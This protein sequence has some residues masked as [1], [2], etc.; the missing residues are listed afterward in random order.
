MPE[1]TVKAA[2]IFALSETLAQVSV[3]E[4]PATPKGRY[5]LSKALDAAVPAGQRYQ[6]EKL[7]LLT[8]HAKKDGNNLPVTQQYGNVIAFDFGEGFGVTPSQAQ[9]EIDQMNDED[10]TLSGVRMI[11]HAE[12][13]ALPITAAQESV[14]IKAG[15]LEDREPE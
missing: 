8:K 12:L 1:I 10:V 11:T 14:L 13:G 2:L 9:T 3:L 6:K 4:P 7:A 15:L 5:A